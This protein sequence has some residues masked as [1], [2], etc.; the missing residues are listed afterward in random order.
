MIL[1]TTSI[2]FIVGA[3]LAPKLGINLRAI[4]HQAVNKQHRSVTSKSS[5]ITYSHLPSMQLDSLLVRLI[6]GKHIHL[7]KIDIALYLSSPKVKT[8]IQSS[9][10]QVRDHLVFILSAK[11]I[12]VFSNAQKQNLLEA[13]ITQQLNL[14]LTT[15]KVKHIQ[16][17]H[18]V[19]N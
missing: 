17:Q 13:E 2:L 3:Y 12:L 8:E 10:Q 1:L 7:N 9:M 14:F 15:G 5:T 4:T 6:S 16:L 11:D 18:T 19:L